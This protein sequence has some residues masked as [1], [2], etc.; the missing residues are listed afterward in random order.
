MVVDCPVRT[1]NELNDALF[2]DTWNP[3]IN[4]F[5]S[6]F[7]YRGVGVESYPLTTSVRSICCLPAVKPSIDCSFGRLRGVHD[8]NSGEEPTRGA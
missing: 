1:W 3:G 7:A 4:R 5:R 8:L 6:T 2:A